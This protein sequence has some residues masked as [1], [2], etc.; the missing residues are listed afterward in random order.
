MDYLYGQN[1][2]LNKL[3]QEIP[4]YFISKEIPCQWEDKGNILRR[5]TEEGQQGKE[6]IEGVRFIEDKGWA[7]IIPDE[8]KPIFNLYIEGYDEEYA[9][10]LG[11]LYD[12]KIKK[13]I[14]GF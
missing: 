10:E 8:E 1:M 13:L 7:M 11:N 12:E 5:L 6:L 9:E 2:T 4:E 3:L 14:K